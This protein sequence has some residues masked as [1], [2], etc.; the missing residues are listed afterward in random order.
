MDDEGR[1]KIKS[2]EDTKKNLSGGGARKFQNHQLLYERDDLLQQ[3]PITAV[4][5]R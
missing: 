3:R 4:S 5:G 1:Y 2:D